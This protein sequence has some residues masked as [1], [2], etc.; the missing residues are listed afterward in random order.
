M[1]GFLSLRATLRRVSPYSFPEDPLMRVSTLAFPALGLLGLL[2]FS[3]PAHAAEPGTPAK[4]RIIVE[5]E[6]ALSRSSETVEVPVASLSRLA[7][8]EGLARVHVVDS[9]TG[10]EVLAQ[11]VDSDGDGRADLLVF[12][13]DFAPNER[14]AFDFTLGEKRVYRREDFR[15]YGRFVRER[16]DDFAWEND[17]TAHRMY[18]A[19]LETWDKEPLTSSTVD[20]WLK[21]TRRLVINDWYLVDDYHRDTGEGADFYSAGK[22][23]GC[24]GSGLWQE[25]ALVVSKNFRLS[26]VLAAGPIRLVFE[27]V[28]P[29]WDKAGIRQETKRIT[30]D[31][32]H[33]LSR[34]ESRYV[35]DGPHPD[36]I[37]VGIKKQ[38]KAERRVERAAGWMRTWEPVAGKDA[39]SFGCGVVF[40][41]AAV[42]EVTEADG[43]Y[44]LVGGLPEGKPVSYYAGAGWD[45]SGDF[46]AAADWDRYLEEWSRRVRSPLRQEVQAP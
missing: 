14:R 42:R 39:G 34:F 20:I 43:N 46:A 4:L 17:R 45:R 15:V 16:Y 35:F 2:A 29:V 13:A 22:S 24:G 36:S 8:D 25:G 10:K 27:L 31:A 26:R 38:T 37:A 19:A 40:D 9:T 12:Q 21:R 23:R 41:P 28:Y 44:L 18:G 30:L 7:S 5:N 1:G 33:N 32:G 11:V 3:A 6:L